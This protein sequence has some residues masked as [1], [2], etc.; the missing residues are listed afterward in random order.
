[1]HKFI[2][3]INIEIVWAHIHQQNKQDIILGSFYCPPGSSISV[4]EELQISVSEI[5]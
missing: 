5:K 2:K 1:M 4:L 3:I